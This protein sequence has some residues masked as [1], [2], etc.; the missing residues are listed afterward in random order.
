MPKSNIT[1]AVWL[2]LWCALLPACARAT[3]VPANFVVEEFAPGAVFDTPTGIT[4]LPD[5]RLLVC[6]KRGRVWMVTN[7]VKAASPLW[8]ADNEVLNNGDRGLLDVA[9]DPHYYQNHY[10]Y[11]LYTVDPDSNGVDDNDD[12]WGRLT[13]YQVGFTDSSTV[14]ASSRT[15]LFG[16]TW[17]TGPLSLS[18]T[19]TIGSLRW[20]SDGT[21]L[22]TTGE[23]AQY[24]NVDYGGQAQDTTAFA[25]GHADPYENIGA[26]RAQ[27]VGSL[28]GKV[29][30]LD[31][32]TGHG[33]AS[34][35]FYDGDPT[36]IRSRVWDYGLRN[37][38]RFTVR[39]GTGSSDPAA[40]NPGALYIGMV[41]WETWE[42]LFSGHSPGLNF[43][44]PCREGLV[45]NTQYTQGTQP[46]HAGCGTLGTSENPATGFTLPILVTHHTDPT[47]SVP[48]GDKG[49]CIVMGSFYTGPNY[50]GQWRGLYFADYG[51]KMI[52][53][54]HPSD[55]DTL[56]SVDDFASDATEQPVD[57]QVDPTSGDIVYDGIATGVIYRIRYTGTV[58]DNPPT[59]VAS[60]T[61]SAGQVP[62]AVAFSSAGSSDPDNDPLAFGW[63]FGDGT[64]STLADPS[65]TYTIPGS[66]TVIL[67]V[68]DGRGGIAY[69][70]LVVVASQAGAF[71]S[72]GVL[73]NFNRP[74][75]AL[76]GSWIAGSTKL[77]I[78]SNQMAESNGNPAAAVWPTV[79]GTSQE[80]YMTI[81]ATSSSAVKQSLMLK[82]QGLDS[83]SDHVEVRYSAQTQ[84]VTIWLWAPATGFTQ[85][86]G[87]FA[88][89]FHAGDQLGARAY[90]NG[91]VEAYANGTLVG[92]ASVP[93]WPFAASTG[94]IGFDLLKAS[95]ARQDDYG[96]GTFVV[97][98][99]TPPTAVI[100]APVDGTFYTIGDSIFIVGTGVD[101]QDDSTQLAYHWDVI[102]HHNNHTH[103]VLE[104]DSAR[105]VYIGMNHDD[106]T[107]VWIEN[108]LIVTDRGG[109]AD[110]AVA[111]IYPE[112]DFQPTSLAPVPHTP[113]TTAPALYQFMLRN[114]GRMPS[115]YTHWVL[116]G[117]TSVV[118]QGDTLVGPLDSILVQRWGPPVLPAGGHT[119][120][121]AVDTLSL[122]PAHE[123]DETNNDLTRGETVVTGPGPD[124][125]PPAIVSGPSTQTFGTFASIGFVTS[126]PARAAVRYG[127]T[128]ALGDSS[129]VD[130]GGVRGTGHD[131]GLRD[132][133]QGTRYYFRI[134]TTDTLG[135]TGVAAVDSFTTGSAPA[136]VPG[137]ARALA[138]SEP[139][140]NPARGLMWLTL[141][142]PQA[143]ADVGLEIVDVA[144]R[145]V[146]R[147]PPRRFAAGAWRLPW[148]AIDRH[149]RPVEPGVYLA[150]VSVGATRFVRRIVVVR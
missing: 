22:V 150:R 63:N 115:P 16:T 134:A 92:A 97:S 6:E 37:P 123:T 36:S 24:T 72:T 93:S 139:S 129:T 138:L 113:G 3:V 39:P 51:Q 30:R 85:V 88:H 124:E 48:P 101:A 71:P 4:F 38:Y 133:L 28:A 57:L 119:L 27:Y 140:P 116:T 54:L 148:P 87:P 69:D 127:P 44:W 26:Y 108:R 102:L 109:L 117:D 35:P 20:G 76:G 41:G 128:L 105:A 18:T 75:G 86:A 83:T 67:N 100:R 149:G 34:N 59:A 143:E 40:G 66:Y 12:A 52:R 29:L 45:E 121:L 78:T 55:N 58:T 53:V 43:G 103:P 19:H 73:D 96:G 82:L 50:P 144:G 47:Q 31:P 9:V 11:L 21:L 14:A 136:G 61:P 104:A 17:S 25:P 145:V 98:S 33:L 126:E 111:A 132:L 94:R 110:T 10:I 81:S 95:G 68:N 32:A 125:F 135:N 64:G 90:A 112:I 147:D 60:A 106:G 79:F 56:L 23:G 107:G 2:A 15:I 131:V 142:L 8:A 137:A 114:N 91:R 13:R 77:V 99:N 130:T 49:N 84:Q 5:G 89:L 7:G 80:A 65:H 62:L 46:S 1:R 74:N 146:W 42:S 120:H 141:S 118:A 122:W 70:T